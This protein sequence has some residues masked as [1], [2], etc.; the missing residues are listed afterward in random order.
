MKSN[1][2]SP[3]G[4][5]NVP[6]T[7]L[8][9]ENGVS[10]GGKRPSLT[11]RTRCYR[12]STVT[13]NSIRPVVWVLVLSLGC[14]ATAQA[15][16]DPTEATI[17]RNAAK[18]QAAAEALLARVVDI[19]SPTE[20]F[21]G[22]RAVG[23]AFAGELRAI[24]FRTRWVELPPE[25]KRAGHLV[26]ET[27]GTRGKRLLLLGHLDTVLA[28]ERFRRDGTRVYGTGIADMK[29]GAVVMLQA[30]LAAGALHALLG[31]LRDPQLEA[32]DDR[33]FSVTARPSPTIVPIRK[34]EAD[35][36]AS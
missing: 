20:N 32:F 22:V 8:S 24:G 23:D 30:L 29:G 1:E 4:E 35:K 3:L 19:E 28:G 17:A 25:M 9:L 31:I 15:E 2:P 27:G 18:G 6:P 14:I 12:E 16:I 10:I 5:P 36:R 11:C 21:V 13:R 34:S 33:T 7:A 26:A